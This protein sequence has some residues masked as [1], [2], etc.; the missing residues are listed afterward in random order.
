[1]EIMVIVAAIVAL[2]VVLP[3]SVIWGRPE[4]WWRLR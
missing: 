1:M 2:F 3:L 4:Q